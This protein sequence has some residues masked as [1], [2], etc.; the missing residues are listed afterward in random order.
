M[1]IGESGE[2]DILKPAYPYSK[3]IHNK[4]PN[5]EMVIVR[6]AGHALIFDKPEE[7]NSIVLGFLRKHSQ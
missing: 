1:D 2:K 3:L 4:I 5:S 6:D 7:F